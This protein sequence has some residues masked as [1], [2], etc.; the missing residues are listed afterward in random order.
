MKGKAIVAMSGGVDSSLAAALMAEQGWEA[1]GVTLKLMPREDTGFGC[2]GSPAD[3]SDAKRVCEALGI[4]HYTLNLSDIFEDKVI[5]PFI[6]AY[7]NAQTPNPCVECNRSLKFG[8]LLGL[9]EAWGASCVATGHYARVEEGRL[10]R[11]KDA[12]KDQTYFLYSLTPRELAKVCFPIGGLEKSEVR[13]KARALGLKT[14]DKAESQEICFVPRRDYRGFLEERAGAG[15]AAF[16]PGPIKD[17]AGRELGRHEGLASYTVGQ[18]KG[19]GLT[20]PE[21][22]YVVGLEPE[23][24]TLVVGGG[25][26]VSCPSFTAGAVSWTTAAPREPFRA[27]VRIRHRHAPAEAVLTVEGSGEVGVRFDEPQRA[28]TPGQ[29]AVFYRGDEVLG[30]GTICRATTGG[31]R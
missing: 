6:D 29:A 26:D 30:G 23:T 9:A 4:A 17:T 12:A 7:L 28:V 3:I 22:R 15:R 25:K 5:K 19:L 10:Y 11:A 20:A 13:A 2:C 14:A 1:V 31:N 21:P 8:T 24:N 27:S 16:S 18:R